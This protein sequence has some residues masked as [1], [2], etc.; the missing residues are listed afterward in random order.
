M[1]N[2]SLH[3]LF[4]CSACVLGLLSGCGSSR[5]AARARPDAAPAHAAGAS[6]TI[7][8]KPERDV[9]AADVFAGAGTRGGQA[10]GVVPE[11]AVG[12]D[13]IPP[14]ETQTD[15]PGTVQRERLLRGTGKY[16]L[17]RVVETVRDGKV[18]ASKSM[19]ADHV[20]VT[21]AANAN[22]EALRTTA[23][24]LG[25][26]IRRKVGNSSAYLVSFPAADHHALDRAVSA[27]SAASSVVASAEAD[28]IVHALIDPN[29][30]F[31]SQCWGENNVGQSGGVADADIDAP[32]AW[33]LTTGS[34]SVL[35]GIIDS[36]VDYTHPDLAENIWINPGENGL[37]SLG[38]DKRSNGVDDDGNGYKDDWRGWNFAGDN[39]DPKDDNFHGTHVAGTIG[40]VGNNFIGVAGV[41]WRVSILPLK[42]LD[43]D[44]NGFTSDATEAVNYATVMGVRLTSNSWGG[45]SASQ[46]LQ[47]AITA[48]G[49]KSI[50]FIVAAGNDGKNNDTTA[51]Y[52]A[53]YTNWNVV[54]VAATD[55]LDR[56]AAFS[57]YG[58]TNVDLAAPGVA[59]PSTLPTYVTAAMTA[60]KIP[61]NYGSL[62]GTS[63]ATPH[64]SGA[65][66]LLWSLYPA[67]SG[68]DVKQ[69]L[70]SM[71]DPI[72]AMSGKAVS[73]GR[74]NVRRLFTN[75]PPTVAI[76]SP[77]NNATFTE[78]AAIT[79]NANAVDA[80]GSVS[81]VDFFRGAVLLGTDATSPYSFTWNGAAAGTYLLT[82]RATDNAGGSTTSA[83]VAVTVNPAVPASSPYLGSPVAVPGTIQAENF[84]N[85]GEGVAFHD[86]DASNNGGAY[87]TTG[88]D[89]EAS[90]DAGGG[91]N[92]GWIKAGEWMGYSV[93][94]SAA[95]VY[96]ISARVA[97]S[98]GGGTFHIEVAGVN[99]T[100]ALTIPNTGNWQSY[101][102]VTKSGV[103][104]AAGPQL[105]K[106]VMDANGA[107]GWVGNLNSI[108]IG[109]API[110]GQTPYAGAAIALPGKVVVAQYDRGGEN[111]AYH[112][113]EQTNY[114]SGTWRPGEG[115]DTDTGRQ[116][117]WIQA[118]EWVEFTV[119]VSVAGPYTL[120]IPV[121][122]PGSGGT[123]HVSFNGVNA[124]GTLAVPNTG[125][126]DVISPLAAS[127]NLNAGTQV[128]QIA[129]DSNG[130]TGFVCGMSD[131]TVTPGSG[132]PVDPQTPHTGTAMEIPGGVTTSSYDNGGE[133]IAYHDEEAYNFM[134]T[135]FR[136]G[137]GVDGKSG[138]GIGWIKAGEWLEYTVHVGTAGAYSVSMPVSHPGVGGTLHV[139]WDGVDVSGAMTVP[140]TASWEINQNI[141]ATMNLSAGTHVMRIAFD[142]NGSTGYVCGLADTIVFTPVANG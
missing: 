137:E 83:T 65:C 119:N 102:T 125:S 75:Q 33:S 29:D 80:D 67:I 110:S 34:A 73:Q 58:A 68:A 7:A 106:V 50:L 93:N 45:G 91:Y 59:I 53:N 39:N 11:E 112:D 88:V 94:A 27:L 20:I 135:S 79:I 96:D 55:R 108:T 48:A 60:D 54:S 82:A 128:M 131:I 61:A 44:G 124:T 139:A 103:S 114:M 37:D 86:L 41:C 129:F 13:V 62:N 132:G 6:E 107:T 98:G 36:G 30:P 63:M 136:P 123:F 35:V 74:L 100:G 24:R 8:V 121:C 109:T 138:Q 2:K 120:T 26:D 57:N 113:V 95:G 49:N 140:N 142:S 127:V 14:L 71:A 1:T 130:S 10:I 118:G 22:E 117:G 105:V 122:H 85:G 72:P 17:T 92:V 84:D 51:T 133:G 15:V 18:V 69:L 28:Y 97:S 111:V 46:S 52:P 16:P 4:F 76:T 56:L 77:A 126:W 42:F 3:I 89:I 134:S 38:R 23:A 19:V 43:K 12:A 40:A 116:I 32:E 31:Y 141:S 104:I 90:G 101:Q 81:A 99:V 87:R 5:D 47:N 25:Y 70:L 78:P 9:A 21:L 115:V 66:A 64:V